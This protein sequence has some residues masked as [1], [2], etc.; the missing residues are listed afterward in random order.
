MLLVVSRDPAP[1]QE[2]YFLVMMIFFQL[3]DLEGY[4]IFSNR[5]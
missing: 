2:D 1:T 3:Y 4:S 5:R